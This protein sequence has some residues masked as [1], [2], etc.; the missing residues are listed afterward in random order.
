MGPG[1][2]GA[3]GGMEAETLAPRSQMHASLRLQLLNLTTDLA[4]L[5][6]NPSDL[7]HGLDLLTRSYT[8]A[9]PQL[10]HP[11]R[12]GSPLRATNRR[13]RVGGEQGGAG[14]GAGRAP[15]ALRR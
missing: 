4:E 2:K 12:G 7:S 8:T 11:G 9:H 5:V 15:L 6:E 14:A 13:H 10:H 1:E 3:A